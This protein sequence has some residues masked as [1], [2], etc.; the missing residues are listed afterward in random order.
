MRSCFCFLTVTVT[1]TVAAP[2]DRVMPRDD[3]AGLAWLLRSET[4]TKDAAA[5]AS[6]I[7]EEHPAAVGRIRARMSAADVAAAMAR[8]DG[9]R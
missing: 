9:G 4:R 7:R 8:A 5:F 1:L 6:F 2:I 3:V